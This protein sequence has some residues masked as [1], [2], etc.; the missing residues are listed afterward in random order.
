[1]ELNSCSLPALDN[2][3]VLLGESHKKPVLVD[4]HRNNRVE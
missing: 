1:M 3:R 2:I 4:Q